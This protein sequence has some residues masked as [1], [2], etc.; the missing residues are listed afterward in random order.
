M[1]KLDLH[2]HIKRF[3][4]L[5]DIRRRLKITGLDGFA[6]T[7]FWEIEFARWLQRRLEDALILI[8]KEINAR[9][10]HILG[11]GLQENIPDYRSAEETIAHIHDQGGVAVL[12]HP[13]L[14]VSS[15]PPIGRFAHLPVDG[16]E[17]FN[18][19]AGPFLW[20]N[21][22]AWLLTRTRTAAL[23]AN[24][25][26]K[27]VDMIGRCYNRIP[28]RSVPEVLAH[29]REG[30]VQRF[31][32]MMWPTPRWAVRTARDVFWGYQNAFCGICHAPL[33]FI[34]KK[35]TRSC[36]ECGRRIR[37]HVVCSKEAHFICKRCRTR[38]D[39]SIEAIVAY[40][41]E[42]GLDE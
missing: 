12:P 39:Y 38:R 29:I 21:T 28:G 30:R 31:T 34:W 40:R 22:L 26:A 36:M 33:H 2:V 9:E 23:L 35:Q 1:L 4:R 16:I 37:T 3:H 10:G 19:R 41:R 24:S 14:G 8:G 7:N 6:V 18:Y 32:R 27:R 11:I 42:N 25:D 15:I 13:F 17:I 20:P 5:A